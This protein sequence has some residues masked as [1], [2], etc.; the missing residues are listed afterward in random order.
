MTVM[1]QNA[2]AEKQE[3]LPEGGLK[4]VKQLREEKKAR[5]EELQKMCADGTDVI[6]EEGAVR[7]NNATKKGASV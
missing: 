5:Q 6:T 1:L 2:N 7:L 4:S 3:E